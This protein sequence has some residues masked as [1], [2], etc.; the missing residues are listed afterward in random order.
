MRVALVYP[1]SKLTSAGCMSP[2]GLLY[3]A[4][5][6]RDNH[7]EVAVF[8]VDG[9]QPGLPELV[10]AVADYRPDVVG[11]PV[12]TQRYTLQAVRTAAREIRN[13]L[14]AARI[15]L[16][17]PHP[18]ALPEQ[19]L[20]WYPE[21]D[22]VLRGEADHT[23]CDLLS[24]LESNTAAPEVPGLCYRTDGRFVSFPVGKP[25]Q[26]LDAIPIPDRKLLW[27]NFRNGVYWRIDS[28]GLADH[29]MTSRG[30]PFD[31]NFCF[32]VE[33]GCRFRSPDKVVEELL[34]LASLGVKEVHFE[35]DLFTIK[36][37]RTVEICRKIRDAGLKLHLKVR[38]RVDTID[39]EM[40]SE[41]KKSGVRTVVYGFESGSQTVLDAMNKKTKVA[42]N[43]DAVR[44]TKKAGLRCYADMFL[45]FPGETLETI[46][47]TE[48]FLLKARPSALNMSILV[49]FPAT[50]VYDQAKAN[51]TLVGDWEVGAPHP[52]VKLPWSEDL[53]ELFELHKKVVRR[54]YLHPLVMLSILR[55]QALHP[56]P[57][58]WRKGFRILRE[59]LHI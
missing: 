17:G 57:R 40:L 9:F 5:S 41:M 28:K 15:V 58:V 22:F 51:G 1:D 35:D 14:P 30:C 38:S 11:I 19:T 12:F 10:N 49:P 21:T 47:E 25:P 50:R 8:D 3:M 23:F 53:T 54:Y 31:C 59:L 42:Q 45:G 33:R 6:V 18:T 2:L 39:P 52:Y 20:E 36:N 29:I 26:D 48:R 27:E 37:A 44:M 46:A 34:Y 13:R 43:H 55:D 56:N 7:H 4:T 16:G 32:K 24:Q